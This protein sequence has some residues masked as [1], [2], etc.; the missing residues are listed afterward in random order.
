MNLRFD[1][2]SFRVP[3]PEETALLGME[4]LLYEDVKCVI[5]MK[6]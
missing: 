6:G 5:C 2:A 4:I 3:D 1:R